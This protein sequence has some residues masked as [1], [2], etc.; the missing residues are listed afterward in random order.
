[1]NPLASEDR[2]EAVAVCPVCR[3]R[4]E[5][6]DACRRCK[7]ELGTLRRVVAAC[8]RSRR[9]ALEHLR[10]GR[11]SEATRAARRLYALCPDAASAHLLAVCHLL[12]EDWPAAA[13]LARRWDET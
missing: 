3:A 1:M 2:A 11:L 13:A 12:C 9:Q 6:S 10:A 8:A 7:C 4:Q 5:W